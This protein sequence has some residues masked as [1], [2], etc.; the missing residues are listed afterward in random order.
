MTL[1]G[2]L[3]GILVSRPS[4]LTPH[5]DCRPPL[6]FSMWTEKLLPAI[7]SCHAI[8][9]LRPILCSLGVCSTPKVVGS[10]GVVADRHYF[11]GPRSGPWVGSGIEVETVHAIT[12]VP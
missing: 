5:L 9:M 12:R 1:C 11:G 7:D 6:F 3:A 4:D 2:P 10:G 8:G